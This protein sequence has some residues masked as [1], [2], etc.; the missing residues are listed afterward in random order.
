MRYIILTLSLIYSLSSLSQ[1]LQLSIDGYIIYP[2]ICTTS[3]G[4]ILPPIPELNDS[5]E[6]FDKSMTFNKLD[7]IETQI[8]DK[9][10]FAG[11][12]LDEATYD[13]IREASGSDDYAARSSANDA[14]GIIVKEINNVFF[15]N[16]EYE[17]DFYFHIS[18][19]FEDLLDMNVQYSGNAMSN[20]FYRDVYDGYTF[21]DECSYITKEISRFNE[22]DYM[23]LTLKNYQDFFKEY[24][25]SEFKLK[26]TCVS[27]DKKSSWVYVVNLY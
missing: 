19:Q 6:F 8:D 15:R 21:S 26:L 5:Y 4:V 25:I 2:F 17:K 24:G 10:Y 20:V 14:L 11:K 18:T 22:D 23:E 9:V 3:E 13:E 12:V 1:E 7:W 16:L 27:E